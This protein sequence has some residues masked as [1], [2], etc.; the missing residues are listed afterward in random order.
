MWNS[1]TR[2]GEKMKFD[3]TMY[4]N[5]I[6]VIRLFGEIWIIMKLKKYAHIFQKLFCKAM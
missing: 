6:A 1:E 4:P 3:I 2:G 5:E